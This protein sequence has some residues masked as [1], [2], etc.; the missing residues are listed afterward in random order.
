MPQAGP[1]L[2]MMYGIGGQTKSPTCDY[3]ALSLYL[4][5]TVALLLDYQAMLPDSCDIVSQ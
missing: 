1:L 4:Y 2:A 3:A 5:D